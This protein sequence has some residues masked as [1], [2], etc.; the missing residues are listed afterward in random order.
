M[1]KKIRCYFTD[2]WN[3]FDY[4]YYLGYLL[5]EFDFIIDDKEPDYL[6]YSC[7]GMNHLNYENCIKIFWQDQQYT[8]PTAVCAF[9]RTVAENQG[10]TV[11]LFIEQ[12]GRKCFDIGYIRK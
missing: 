4:K 9:G 3:D 8:D 12:A 10:R 11:S 2:F 5:S 6:F 7:F 1:K